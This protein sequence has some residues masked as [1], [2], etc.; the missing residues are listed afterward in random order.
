MLTRL[1]NHG[2]LA[3]SEGD[4][5]SMTLGVLQISSTTR[6]LV[7]RFKRWGKGDSSGYEILTGLLGVG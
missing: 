3:L 6:N 4:H 7:P 5:Y 2:D 1:V